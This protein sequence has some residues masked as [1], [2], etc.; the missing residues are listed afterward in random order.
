MFSFRKAFPSFV[1]ISLV[2]ACAPVTTGYVSTVGV[3]APTVAY[4]TPVI[5]TVVAAPVAVSYSTVPVVA[6]APA[7]TAQVV[8]A[9]ATIAMPSVVNAAAPVSLAVRQAVWP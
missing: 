6:T 3:V 4:A 7:V 5:S 9:P 1:A 8:S 2:T